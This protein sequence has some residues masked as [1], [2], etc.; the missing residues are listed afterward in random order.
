MATGIKTLMIDA[1]LGDAAEARIRLAAALAG[2]FGARL[3]GLGACAACPPVMGPFGET[4][5][6][7]TIVEAEVECVSAA[8]QSAA[9]RFEAAAKDAGAPAE[10][11]S[12]L[13]YPG[14]ALARESRAAD[15]LVLGR[16]GDAGGHPSAAPG[17]VLMRAG[18]PILVA[19]P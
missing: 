5:A 16:G 19:P 17:D 2:R 7:S 9:D 12:F 11:W 14:E 8:L 13:E 15:L 1:G 6:V 10:W 18:R 3:V 4:A